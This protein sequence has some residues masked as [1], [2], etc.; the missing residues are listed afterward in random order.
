[1]LNKK[2]MIPP[3]EMNEQQILMVKNMLD[4]NNPKKVSR[5]PAS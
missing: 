4:K 5:I 2:K 3:S 1:M